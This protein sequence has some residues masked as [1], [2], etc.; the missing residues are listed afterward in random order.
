MRTCDDCKATMSQGY[1]IDAGVKYLCEACHP[2]H[3]TPEQW[4]EEYANGE[5]ESYWTQWEEGDEEA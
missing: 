1:V 2:K 5:S 4:A 3:Y